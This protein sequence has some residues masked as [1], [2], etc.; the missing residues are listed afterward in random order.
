MFFLYTITMFESI[1]LGVVQGVA[2]WLPV[3][4]EGMIILVKN[5]VFQSGMSFSEMISF[6][7]FLHLGTLLAAVVYFRKKIVT[8]IKNIFYYKN[9]EISERRELDFLVIATAVS[10]VF[11]YGILKFIEY[12]NHF[13]SNE[14]IINFVV[15]LFLCITAFFLYLSEQRKDTGNITLTSKKAFI[16]GLFQSFAAIPGI[17]RSGSTIAAMGLLGIEKERVLELSFIL[18]IP[19]VL[20]ANIILNADLLLQ[21]TLHHVVALVFAFIFGII[22]IELLL[23]LVKKIRFSYFV[24]LFA[25]LLILIQIILII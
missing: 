4:S 20:F 23:R 7:I 8:L 6:A 11:G 25:L 19:L 13:F 21:I 24:G 22:T 9:I 2:E 1:I 17:S 14:I 16:T 10:G 5:N 12:N 3:S 15:A 18:S